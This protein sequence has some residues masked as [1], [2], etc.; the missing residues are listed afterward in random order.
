MHTAFVD[1]FP[2]EGEPD[3]WF[4][5]YVLGRDEAWMN[6]HQHL[7]PVAPHDSNGDPIVDEL[8]LTEALQSL[9]MRMEG[10]L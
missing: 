9:V 4:S 6:V 7:G 8:S 5:G 3:A 10:L 2:E 1:E